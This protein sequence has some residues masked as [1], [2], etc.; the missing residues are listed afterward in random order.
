MKFFLL[1]ILFFILSCAQL[2]TKRTDKLSIVQGI[3][4]TK[5]VEF[6]IVSFKNLLLRFELR[7][8]EGE[9]INPDEVKTITR[10]FSEYVV[11]KILFSRNPSND[12][13]LYVYDGIKVIDQRL[14]GRGQKDI[15][16]L[17]LVVASCLNDFYQNH[18]KIWNTLAQRK[19]DYLLLIGDNVYTD[20]ASSTTSQATDPEIIWKRYVDYR[21]SIPFY[22]QEKL[23]PTHAVWDDHDYGLNNGNAEFPHKEASK[24]VFD[25][26]WAQDLSMDDWSKGQGVGGLLT[27]G[28]YNL[29]FLDGRSFR[30]SQSEKSHLGLDQLAWLY[31]KLRQEATPSFIIKGDQF[32]GGYH[33]FESYEGNHPNEFQQFVNELKGINTPFIFLSGDRHL[34]EIMQFPRSLFGKP[35]FEI[36]SSPLHART[37]S[38]EDRNPWRVV[39]EKGRVNFTV[40]ESMAKDNHWFLDVENVG[41]GGDIFFRRELAVYI[42]DLQNN[43]EEIRKRRSGKRRYKR[44]N[45]SKGRRR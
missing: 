16:K 38:D 29:Y 33:T 43:L 30:S 37:F 24:E 39:A 31:S 11:H 36:T 25:A 2:P 9:I 15:S 3:T 19:P 45:R 42:K 34:S 12:F 8:S 35:S 23:I 6:S 20:V 22:F 10:N 27:L 41:E 1:L 21:L 5:E 4:N 13:N 44:I 26:F 32:F 14:V 17:R 18:F 7:S 28:D 40:I